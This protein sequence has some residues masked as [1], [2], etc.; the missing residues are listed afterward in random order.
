[1]NPAAATISLGN[2]SQLYDGSPK[3]AIATTNPPGLR[4]LSLTYDG[5][6]VAPTNAGSYAVVASLDNPDYTAPDA[7]G[8][9]VIAPAGTA[10]AVASSLNPATLGQAVTFTATVSSS[11]GTPTGTVVFKDGTAILGSQAPVAGSASLTTATLAVG[12][13]L[14]TAVYDG[15]ANFAGSTSAVLTQSVGYAFS[16]FFAPV[17][18]L[19]T[20]NA[21]KAGSAVAVKFSLGGNQELDVLAP[22]Y[23]AS[24]ALACD[25]TALVN[26]IEETTTAGSSGLTYDPA[27]GQYV[28]VWK[29][30]KTWAGTC[31][32]LVVR[33]KDN[34]E[35]RANFKL[36]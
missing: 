23:P 29:T 34:T 9:L 20:M 13:H 1:V 5:S 27:S 18:N 35:H 15:A 17:D 14:I 32:Q 10:T 12:A 24:G 19:P 11:G 16:G 26:A 22:G 25:S 21:V 4:V 31:R 8:T 36:K 6:A 28:Y 30:D 2:L 3:P 33:L 7:L